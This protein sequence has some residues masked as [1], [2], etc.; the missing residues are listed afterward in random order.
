[1]PNNIIGIFEMYFS[2][3]VQLGT[4]L[5]P[6]YLSCNCWNF[7]ATR[8]VRF[9]DQLMRWPK[10]RTNHKKCWRSFVRQNIVPPDFVVGWFQLT[11]VLW[12]RGL[13]IFR[14][15]MR[16]SSSSQLSS[17]SQCWMK[18]LCEDK[19]WHKWDT[20]ETLRGDCIGSY[21]RGD[22]QQNLNR[23]ERNT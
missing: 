19:T 23:C 17:R 9:P 6:Y 10:S 5:S 8:I 12:W 7:D 14:Q 18:I 4:Y 20:I 3:L 22:L 13:M 2:F 21:Q 15:R 1:M 11:V 16:W